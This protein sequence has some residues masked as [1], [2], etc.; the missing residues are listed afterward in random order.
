[1]NYWKERI[2]NNFLSRTRRFVSFVIWTVGIIILFEFVL[3]NFYCVHCTEKSSMLMIFSLIIFRMWHLFLYFILF[4]PITLCSPLNTLCSELWKIR[5]LTRLN[6]KSI[7]VTHL[8][9][10]SKKG[11]LPTKYYKELLAIH[12]YITGV[13]EFRQQVRL[14]KG[15]KIWGKK[16]FNH[17]KVFSGNS[18]SFTFTTIKFYWQSRLS[19]YGSIHISV[20][21][22][23]GV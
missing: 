3:F 8:W 15:I 5:C 14:L 10:T 9:Y 21:W 4:Y 12:I 20:F 13:P 17:V 2:K 19:V 18:V 16:G 6:I 1:M 7:C 22:I 11:V 23:T